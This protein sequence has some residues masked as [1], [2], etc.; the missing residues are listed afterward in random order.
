MNSSF[1]LSFFS[2]SFFLSFS[3]SLLSSLSLS[4]PAPLFP[5][6]SASLPACLAVMVVKG[7]FYERVAYERKMA[8]NPLVCPQR[9]P[10][11]STHTLSRLTDKCGPFISHTLTLRALVLPL[12]QRNELREALVVVEDKHYAVC[13]LLLLFTLSPAA[14]ELDM[15]IQRQVGCLC[16]DGD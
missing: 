12:L 15:C 4:T 5:C 13:C 7:S 14:G 10:A 1:F 2:I 9:C 3:S 8:D 6:C 11:P 16:G